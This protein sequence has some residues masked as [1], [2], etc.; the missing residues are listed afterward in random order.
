MAHQGQAADYYDNRDTYQEYQPPQGAPSQG[1]QSYPPPQQGYDQQYK[2]PQ[3][4]Q[5]EPKYNAQ[6][7]TYG[8]NFNA[9]QD[10]NQDFKDTFKIQ[11]PKWNDLWA[12]LLVCDSALTLE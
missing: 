12:G 9:P 7:P 2:P 1:Y 10:S 6:P 8:E 4:T 5:Y 11:K 3:Q